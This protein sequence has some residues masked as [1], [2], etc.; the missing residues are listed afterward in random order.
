MG[1]AQREPYDRVKLNKFQKCKLT[2]RSDRFRCCTIVIFSRVD[3]ACKDFKSEVEDQHFFKNEKW[4]QW[5]NS[6]TQELV[7]VSQLLV[8]TSF[9]VI[10]ISSY[11]LK[12]TDVFQKCF[13]SRTQNRPIGQSSAG[14]CYKETLPV[15]L[16]SFFQK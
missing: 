11:N 15:K 14:S 16:V 6:Q 3:Q 10:S 8:F 1:L 4:N 12:K 2:K 9:S 7:L 13:P 5:K